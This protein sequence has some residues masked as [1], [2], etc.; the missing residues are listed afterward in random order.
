MKRHLYVPWLLL[1]F[2]LV[3][4]ATS[5]NGRPIPGTLES[6]DSKNSENNT[7]RT[8]STPNPDPES[9]PPDSVQAR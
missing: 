5:D 4:C 8:N 7:P 1:S 3:G 9:Q 2:V 6:T